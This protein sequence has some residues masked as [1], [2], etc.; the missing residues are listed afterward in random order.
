MQISTFRKAIGAAVAAFAAAVVASSQ[1]G[2]LTSADWVFALV[3]A[4]IAG[5][6]VY[7]VP[8]APAVPAPATPAPP[9][10]A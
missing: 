4:V 8:N 2:G 10:A 7:L 5:G 6:A 3:A 1:K 9:A